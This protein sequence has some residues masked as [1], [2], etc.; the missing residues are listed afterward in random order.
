MIDSALPSFNVAGLGKQNCGLAG[1]IL[2]SLGALSKGSH[3]GC[4]L[5]TLGASEFTK[6]PQYGGR[7]LGSS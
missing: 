5:L 3:E 7:G 1:I 2:G 4:E 6:R